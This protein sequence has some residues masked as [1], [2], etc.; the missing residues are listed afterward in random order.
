MTGLFNGAF[1]KTIA[2][3]QCLVFYDRA[4]VATSI[5]SLWLRCVAAPPISDPAPS[6]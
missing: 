4:T 6:K 2:D 5:N 1:P 3:E